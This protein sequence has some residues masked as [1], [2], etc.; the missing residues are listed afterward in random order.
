[1]SQDSPLFAHGSIAM[2][3]MVGSLRQAQRLAADDA[4]RSGRPEPVLSVD[5]R[6]PERAVEI[7]GYMR[8][9]GTYQEVQSA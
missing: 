1:M 6:H 8:A 5:L 2:P 9:D 7:L 4:R 3:R